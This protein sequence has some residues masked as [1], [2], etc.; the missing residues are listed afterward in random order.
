MQS[1]P[2]ATDPPAGARISAAAGICVLIV[3]AGAVVALL[4]IFNFGFF[5]RP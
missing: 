2:D 5:S 1:E 4:A 3:L